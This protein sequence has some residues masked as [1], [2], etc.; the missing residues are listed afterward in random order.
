MLHAR[1]AKGIETSVL[2]TVHVRPCLQWLLH[3]QLLEAS[4]NKF[5]FVVLVHPFGSDPQ[6]VPYQ[7]AR[8]A[9][10]APS[11]WQNAFAAEAAASE[12][13]ALAPAAEDAGTSRAGCCPIG[14]DQ[15]EAAGACR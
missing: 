5:G 14:S 4:A 2:E 12:P 7:R 9:V 15:S 8:N 6:L 11:H 3:H 13:F 10:D 1:S